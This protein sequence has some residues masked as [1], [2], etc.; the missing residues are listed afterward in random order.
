MSA[1]PPR[2]VG[3]DPAEPLP[4]AVVKALRLVADRLSL[5]Q[6]AKARV[7]LEV[8][9]D[10]SD[11]YLHFRGEGLPSAEAERRTLERCDL[12]DEALRDLVELHTGTLRR[13]L[14]SLANRGRRPGEKLALAAVTLVAGGFAAGTMSSNRFFE[15]AGVLALWILLPTLIGIGGAAAGAWRLWLGREDARL[16]RHHLALPLWMAAASLAVAA[17]GTRIV[18][19]GLAVKLAADGAFSSAPLAS[20]VAGVAANMTTALTGSLVCALCWFVLARRAQDIDVAEAEA[21]LQLP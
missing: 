15:Q 10:M 17:L 7:L 14:D 6:P 16:R 5:H 11:L 9:A 1:A 2:S 12:S 19:R 21:L 4:D 20:G 13:L 8:A 3:V 18:V